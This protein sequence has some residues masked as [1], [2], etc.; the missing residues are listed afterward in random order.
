[1]RYMRKIE[2]TENKISTY[3]DDVLCSTITKTGRT[4][5][6]FIVEILKCD[7]CGSN[8]KGN[9]AY[10]LGVGD[11]LNIS[12]DAC[13]NK[14]ASLI[15]DMLKIVKQCAFIFGNEANYPEGTVGYT[16]AQESKAI[17]DRIHARIT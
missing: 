9:N 15:P 7:C 14:E 10:H 2:V 8:L 6:P 16:L 3:L 5:I 13:N 1:M 4:D 17:I 12:C 11:T